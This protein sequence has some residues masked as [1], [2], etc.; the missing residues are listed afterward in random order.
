MNAFKKIL[1]ISFSTLILSG[2]T[3]TPEQAKK[4][5]DGLYAGIKAI[6]VSKPCQNFEGYKILQS[7]EKKRGTSYYSQIT[8][9][10]IKFYEKPCKNFMQAID[11][12]KKWKD[13]SKRW[14]DFN[15]LGDWDDGYYVD[16]FGDRDDEGWIRLTQNGLFSNIATTN[17]ILR[18]EMIL[19]EGSLKNNPYFMLYEY[20]GTNPVKGIFSDI[21][22][23][24]CRV[25]D[26]DGLIFNLEIHQKESWDYFRLS[27]GTKKRNKGAKK[28]KEI[29]SSES[30]AKFSCYN[31]NFTSTKYS[32]SLDFKYYKNA[33]RKLKSEK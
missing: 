11:K 18:I 30:S 23:I 29:I 27:Y 12:S 8:S 15:E 10:K 17:S 3:F 16:E 1:T 2:Y 25:K 5:I 31:E 7:L 26:K 32:F 14:E 13:G 22:S 6:P 24:I 33:L 9:Q 4:E 28:F 21:N 20:G 19:R